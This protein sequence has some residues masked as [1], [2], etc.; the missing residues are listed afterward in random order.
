MKLTSK[1]DIQNSLF[2]IKFFKLATL[3]WR[4]VGARRLRRNV[5]L[6]LTFYKTK[7]IPIKGMAYFI[8]L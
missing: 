2:D 3:H 8:Y 4:R 7:A 6:T 1:F 5:E